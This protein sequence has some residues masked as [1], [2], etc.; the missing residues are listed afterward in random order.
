AEQLKAF[1]LASLEEWR[2]R[3]F[4]LGGPLG[5]LL[6]RTFEIIH[7]V[8]RDGVDDDV[9]L[10]YGLESLER[11]RDHALSRDQ[12][13]DDP[14]RNLVYGLS[15]AVKT[16][17]DSIREEENG[18]GEGTEGGGGDG[19]TPSAT[20]IA[21]VPQF[22]MGRVG[23][24]RSVAVA[25]EVTAVV[26]AVVGGVA[27]AAQQPDEEEEAAQEEWNSSSSDSNAL[28]LF[29]RAVKG[30]QQYSLPSN[31]VTT[32]FTFDD[33]TG[34]SR[35]PY[36]PVSSLSI[37]RAISEEPT[38][39][40]YKKAI[41]A[42]NAV[43][44]PWN[45]PETL[46]GCELCDRF[47]ASERGVLRHHFTHSAARCPVCR[48]FVSK[49]KLKK[50]LKEKHGGSR[51]RGGKAK[52]GWDQEESDE[53][54][55][56]RVN[57]RHDRAATVACLDESVPVSPPTEGG[58]FPCERCDKSFASIV[59]LHR[60][61][62][63]H[64]DTQYEVGQMSWP[65]Y[66]PWIEVAFAAPACIIC[67]FLLIILIVVPLPNG[68]KA[69][70]YINTVAL[71]FLALCQA[72]IAEWT[73]RNTRGIGPGELH[74]FPLIFAHQGLYLISTASLFYITCERLLLC[75]LPTF[76]ETR[77]WKLVPSIV[78]AI[79][80]ESLLVVPLTLMLQYDSTRNISL[81]LTSL[82]EIITLSLLLICY[83]Q[84]RHYYSTLFADVRL[85]IRYQVKEVIE[86]TRVLIPICVISLCLK[87]SIEVLASLVFTNASSVSTFVLVLRFVATTMG[88]VEP[89]L[90]MLRHR[91]ISRRLSMLINPGRA[92][93]QIE[94]TRM[95]SEETTRSYFTVLRRE[96][97]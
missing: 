44:G 31:Q 50:H 39:I 94:I 19:I 73:T 64:D 92:D 26:A 20:S 36:E 47:F 15:D 43:P 84:S 69:F 95:S 97:T 67:F 37:K 91:S 82:T 16:M 46:Y 72:L 45:P 58:R 33:F 18:S 23:G 41:V 53:E 88:Y 6:T 38:T 42:G 96:W 71:F 65:S 79:V 54:E 89:I 28:P 68:C 34:A 8:I 77:K 29:K 62:K 66:L 85:N 76:Y 57:S 48:T 21:A 5:H 74:F 11:E 93:A 61:E 17:V 7:T 59:S 10:S 86:L 13:R 56:P 12:F 90:L 14:V 75:V 87:L 60:H 4:E 78:G 22:V 83:R 35:P 30:E 25:A 27:T 49:E 9:S 80:L 1:R 24:A 63:V 70:L 3:S 40:P 51:R 2:S 32:T 52:T 81:L 55:T